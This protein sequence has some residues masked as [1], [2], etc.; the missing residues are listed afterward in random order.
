MVSLVKQRMDQLN[1]KPELVAHIM[2]EFRT[3][4]VRMR[5]EDIPESTPDAY[6]ATAVRNAAA[7]PNHILVGHIV[8]AID[9]MVPPR[10]AAQSTCTPIGS[11]ERIAVYAQRFASGEA[12]F[13]PEDSGEC[14]A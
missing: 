4:S 10:P 14:Y 7:D 1:I 12:I 6:S 3:Q 5:S 8:D 13:H 11:E 2:D 9:T